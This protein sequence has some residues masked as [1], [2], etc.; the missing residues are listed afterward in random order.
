[1]VLNRPLS[2]FFLSC[3]L[4]IFFL[5]IVLFSFLFPSDF[6]GNERAGLDPLLDMYGLQEE[7]EEEEELVVPSVREPT[8]QVKYSK[9]GLR[10]RITFMRIRRRIHLFILMQI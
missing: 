10:I 1:M 6:Q 9:P 8:R 3:P 5:R 4:L 7:E 2:I